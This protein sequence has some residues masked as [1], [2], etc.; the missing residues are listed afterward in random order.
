MNI[1]RKNSGEKYTPF[2]H[3]DMTTEVLFNPDSGCEKANITLSTLKKGS[4][5]NDEIH[6][7]SDQIFYV[8]RGSMKFFSK[9][10]HIATLKEG[11][12]ILVPAGE[13]HSAVNEED[14]ECIYHALTVPPLESTH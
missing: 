1:Y 8:V 6:E 12:S 13:A 14:E 7:Y 10:K 4:G 11:D 5:S 3:F 9:G 2:S